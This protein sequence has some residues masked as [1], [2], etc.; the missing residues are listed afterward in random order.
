VLE[1]VRE[2]N[3]VIRMPDGDGN[4]TEVAPIAFA[5]AKAMRCRLPFAAACIV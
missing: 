4:C 5:L 2:I 3:S 1:F